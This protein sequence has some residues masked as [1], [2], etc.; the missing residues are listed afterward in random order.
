MTK[1]EDAT[2]MPG[3]VL[4]MEMEAR[5]TLAVELAAPATMA[6]A[7]PWRT[8]MAP[9]RRGSAISRTAASLVNPLCLRNSKYSRA[10]ASLR[11]ERAGSATRMPSSGTASESALARTATVSPT[12][13]TSR[14]I[15]LS[16]MRRAAR[17]V[18]SSRPSGS[19]SRQGVAW[20]R[21]II[22]SVKLMGVP[23]RWSFC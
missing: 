2:L 9:Q 11:G 14:A 17:I 8:N 22:R 21:L 4:M 3:F 13:V 19:T 6:S 16:R 1:Q 5:K 18:R 10:K 15:F 20:A 7:T 12:S 23:F